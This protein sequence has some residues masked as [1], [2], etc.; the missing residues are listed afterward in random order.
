[1][2]DKD[3]EWAL[4]RWSD[5]GLQDFT[6]HPFFFIL[7]KLSQRRKTAPLNTANP[8]DA[9]QG[10]GVSDALL[11]RQ[12]AAFRTREVAVAYPQP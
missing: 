6:P 7:S 3:G 11:L 4:R 9:F 5:L 1:M 8:D 2:K 10:S 12:R